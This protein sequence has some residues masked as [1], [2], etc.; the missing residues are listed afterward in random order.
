MMKKFAAAVVSCRKYDVIRIW[1]RISS[2]TPLTH[3]R[4]VCQT[5]DVLFV[6]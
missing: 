1:G 2:R 3:R 5:V 4:G 6:A